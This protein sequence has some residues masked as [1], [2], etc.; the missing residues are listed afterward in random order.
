MVVSA[1]QVPAAPALDPEHVLGTS[2]AF[3]ALS[4]E[5]IS[6]LAQASEVVS[7]AEGDVLAAGTR[8]DA[9]YVVGAGRASLVSVGAPRASVLE[10]DLF[11]EECL[12]EEARLGADILAATP[13]DV[14]RI[15]KGAL[16]DLLVDHPELMGLLFEILARRLVLRALHAS[17]L[18]TPLPPRT[19]LEV[20]GRFG[21]RRALAGTVLGIRGRW[22]DGMCLLLAGSVSLVDAFGNVVL[23][24]PGQAFGHGSLFSTAPAS[25]AVRVETESVLLRLPVF[26][27]MALTASHPDF[28]AH[29]RRVA[30]AGRTV[31]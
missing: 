5:A 17:P 2:L 20:A 31:V 1:P 19:R 4:L 8:A 12:L 23:V 9:L 26:G 16:D 7:F 15:R 27:F 29:L 28:A 22:T 6:A 11:G 13:L 10:G 14:L 18:F 30:Q 25:H 24:A 21:V 3:A